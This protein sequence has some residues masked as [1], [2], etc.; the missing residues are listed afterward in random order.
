MMLVR[1]PASGANGQ[2]ATRA[3]CPL[4]AVRRPARRNKGANARQ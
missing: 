3:E 1:E 2:A 4:L